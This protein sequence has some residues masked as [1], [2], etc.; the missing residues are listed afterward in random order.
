MYQN[1]GGHPA[2]A[3]GSWARFQ[4]TMPMAMGIPTHHVNAMFR[5]NQ[6]DHM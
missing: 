2:A 5:P 6:T 4:Q 1:K 3:G